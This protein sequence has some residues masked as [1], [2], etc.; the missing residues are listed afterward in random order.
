MIDMVKVVA[1]QYLDPF[2]LR[3]RFSNGASGIRDFADIVT[4]GG[5]MLE[6]LRDAAYFKRVFLEYGVLTWP[7]GYDVDAIALHDE[8]AAIGALKSAS[9][10]AAE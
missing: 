9:A 3:V 5:V 7:N 1:V 10:D 6:P 2:R 8:M 4:E